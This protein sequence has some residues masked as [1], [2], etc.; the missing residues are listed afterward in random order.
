MTNTCVSAYIGIGRDSHGLKHKGF[1]VLKVERIQRPRHWFEYAS[2]KN[3]IR[4]RLDV[5]R[6]IPVKTTMEW[7]TYLDADV[8]EVYLFHGTKPDFVEVIKKHGFEE[9]VA[10]NGLFGHGIYFAE[11]SSKSDEYIVPDENGFCF[12]FMSRVVLGNAYIATQMHKDIKRPPCVKGHFDTTAR[13]DHERHDSLV[14]EIDSPTYPGAL[15]KR[16]REFVVYDRAQ[17]YPEFLI[18]FKRV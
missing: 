1:Q 17:T 9:R 14:G 8:N 11:N 3:F 13:C 4:S 10:S 18:T 6:E 16:Y 7:M 5:D 2:K 12:I 15:L